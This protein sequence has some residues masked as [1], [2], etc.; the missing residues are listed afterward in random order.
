M[1]HSAVAKKKT[2]HFLSVYYHIHPHSLTFKAQAEVSE[3]HQWT[4][5]IQNINMKSEIIGKYS[6]QLPCK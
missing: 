3:K 6:N 2:N 1:L 4:S 5:G